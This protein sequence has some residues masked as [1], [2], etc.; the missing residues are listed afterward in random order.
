MDSGTIVTILTG[1]AGVA[2]GWVGGRRNVTVAADTV[3]M[4]TVQ[5]EALQREC[6]KIPPLL[7]RI[8]VLEELITQRADV[9]AVKAIV[10][11]IEEK[12]DERA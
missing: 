7:D 9:E 6:A 12:L 11:R 3:Q 5:I 10:T 1:A 8:G 2:G 4:L